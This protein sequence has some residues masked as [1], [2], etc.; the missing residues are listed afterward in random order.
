[1]EFRAGQRVSRDSKADFLQNAAA[2]HGDR[3]DYKDFE[4]IRSSVRSTVWCKKHSKKFL[5]SPNNHLRGKGCPSCG[6]QSSRGEDEVAAFLALH[7]PV[8]QRD[9]VLIAPLEVDI[10]APDIGFAVEYHGLNWHTGDEKRKD[11]F[12]KYAGCAAQG[13]ELWQIFEDEWTNK[14]ELIKARLL[15]RV[16]G[17]KKVAARKCVIDN[18]QPSVAAAFLEARHVQGSKTGTINLGL[19]HEGALVAVASFGAQRSGAMVVTDGW[20]VLRFASEGTVVGGFSKLFSA[21]VR[22]ASPDEVIS[23]CDLRWGNGRVYKA[24]GF[25]LLSV[26]EPDYWWVPARSSRSRVPRYQTQK[27][28]LPTHPILA[29]HYRDDLSEIE[30]CESAGWRRIYGVG[31][32]KWRWTP[33]KNPDTLSAP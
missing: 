14:K 28:K 24:T 31:H 22:L 23:Y 2:V 33:P 32:Q 19:R 29:Q 10:Y 1:V 16:G 7:T 11:H 8:V 4:Y 3:Y 9:H 12:R 13:V 17:A 25:E 26:T 21:F 5:I 18:I 15:A 30:I 6:I 27:H 20:E